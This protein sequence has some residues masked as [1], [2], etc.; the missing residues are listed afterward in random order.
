M[1]K[2]QLEGTNCLSESAYIVFHGRRKWIYSR[3]WFW[4]TC[5]SLMEL[6]AV[7]ILPHQ[8][9]TANFASAILFFLFLCRFSHV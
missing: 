9:I 2:T 6:G 1:A 4:N 7:F 5:G 3:F 8:Y